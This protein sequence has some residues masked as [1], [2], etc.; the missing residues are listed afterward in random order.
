MTYF[1]RLISRALALPRSGGQSLFDPFEQT[2]DWPL[3]ESPV[4]PATIA[5]AVEPEPTQPG[6]RPGAPPETIIAVQ[7]PSN[8]PPTPPLASQAPSEFLA[9]TALDPVQPRQ[10]TQPFQPAAD[11]AEQRATAA[12]KMKSPQ[13]IAD[14]MMQP[15][16]ERLQP[17]PA[18]RSPVPPVEAGR[19]ELAPAAHR[20]LP[21]PRPASRALPTIMPPAP[22]SPVV[23]RPP[24]SAAE[25]QPKFPSNPA[26]LSAPPAKPTAPAF[27]APK[28]APIKTGLSQPRR[29]NLRHGMGIIR[30]GLNQS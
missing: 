15:F 25:G 29:D 18:P 30:F 19:S 22:K 12:Q 4:K 1:D 17:S 26:K 27:L 11:L 10:A 7:P 28:A 23:P 3:D 6:P 16:L 9:S 14:A 2:A 21:S 20:P 5:A 24:R 13:D 8:D